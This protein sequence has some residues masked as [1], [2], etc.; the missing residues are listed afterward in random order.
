MIRLTVLYNLPEGAD[1]E[2]FL[3]WRLTNHQQTNESM[4]GVVRTDFA[5]ITDCWPNGSMPDY[6]FQTTV[7]WPDRETFDAS[8]YDE[9]VQA[10]LSE[11]LK[12]VG[13][14]SFFVSNVLIDSSR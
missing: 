10:K 8:F 11:N 13:K 1:E 6:R 12:R 3:N 2:E 14:Y 9:D 7:E 5:R 4:P